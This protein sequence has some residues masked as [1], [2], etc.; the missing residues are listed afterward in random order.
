MEG[1]SALHGALS[2]RHL[3]AAQATGDHCLAAFGAAGHRP[4][5]GLLERSSKGDAPLELVGDVTGDQLRIEFRHAHLIDVHS[6][7]FFR[8]RL[9]LGAQLVDFLAAAADDDAGLRGMDRH[10][11]LIGVSV[12]LHLGDAGVLQRLTDVAADAQVLV[13]E[14]PVVPFGKPLALPIVDDADA[15]PG[16]MYFLTHASSPVRPRRW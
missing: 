3:R 7:A 10:G 5:H 9:Q 1:H 11:D 14:L 13:E 8:E 6:N 12:E 15:E 16:W 2:A 4:A